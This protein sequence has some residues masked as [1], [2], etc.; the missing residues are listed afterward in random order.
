M[1][2]SIRLLIRA[3]NHS[4]RI[5][6]SPPSLQDLYSEIASTIRKSESSIV[7]FYNFYSSWVKIQDNIQYTS[8]IL[9]AIESGK[10]EIEIKVE[11]IFIAPATSCDLN[12]NISRIVAGGDR[13]VL[14]SV[15]DSDPFRLQEEESKA[16]LS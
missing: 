16:I 7:L 15:A 12:L 3:P 8:V 6:A 1:E 4:F 14:N 9:K 13:Q 2:N 10:R 11:I 5:M